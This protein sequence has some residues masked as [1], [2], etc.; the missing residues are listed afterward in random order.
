MKTFLSAN[1]ICGII[2]QLR[3]TNA[4]AISNKMISLLTDTFSVN[5]FLIGIAVT[6]T[7]TQ[8]LHPSI[9]TDTFLSDVVVS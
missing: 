4:T 5:P 8:T 7:K 9:I 6:H 1:S 2:D 3:R